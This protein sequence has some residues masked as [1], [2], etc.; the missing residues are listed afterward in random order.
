MQEMI[1]DIGE[2]CVMW[3]QWSEREKEEKCLDSMSS[4][5]RMSFF[6]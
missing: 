4:S 2:Q 6:H 3:I 5:A 1:V